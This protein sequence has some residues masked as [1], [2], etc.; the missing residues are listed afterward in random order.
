[1]TTTKQKIDWYLKIHTEI[2]D[3][4]LGKARKLDRRLVGLL[5]ERGPWEVWLSETAP[6]AF[7]TLTR[8][9]KSANEMWVKGEVGEAR[10]RAFRTAVQNEY[11]LA[12]WAAQQYLKFQDQAAA[13][14]AL[15]PME[16]VLNAGNTR[17][18]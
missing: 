17:Y 9:R 6:E 8:E 12:I 16:P 13:L 2:V 5:Q 3:L 15:G 1:M 7:D 18:E 11:E 4:Y 14:K 10:S